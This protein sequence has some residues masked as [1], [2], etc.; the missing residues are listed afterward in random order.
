M[1]RW[2]RRRLTYANVIATLALCLALN[3]GAYAAFKIP[4][5]SIGSAQLKNRAVAPRKVS[6]SAIRLSRGK[7]GPKGPREPRGCPVPQVRRAL[8]RA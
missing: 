3:V 8:N 6:P 5:N 2:I 1:P 7:K 4:P